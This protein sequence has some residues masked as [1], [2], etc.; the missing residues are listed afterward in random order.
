LAEKTP[1]ADLGVIASG[2]PQSTQSSHA[3]YLT[4]RALLPPKWIYEAEADACGKNDGLDPI[5]R[6]TTIYREPGSRSWCTTL[7]AIGERA[8]GL[9]LLPSLFLQPLPWK[10]LDVRSQLLLSTA[11]ASPRQRRTALLVGIIVLGGFLATAPFAQVKL[12][13]FP[14]TILIQNTLTL[15]NDTL[16]AAVLFGQYAVNRSRGLCIL[17]FGFLFT[18]LM[19]AAH[20]LSF[21]EVFSPTGLLNGGPQGTPWLYMVWHAVL[22]ATVVAFA[23][24]RSDEDIDRATRTTLAP[25]VMTIVVAGCLA[26]ASTWLI[27]ARHDWLP[28]LIEDGRLLSTTKI[29]VAVQLLLPLAALLALATHK[30][31]SVLDIWLMVLMLTWLCT[32]T[33]VLILGYQRYDVGWY[34]GRIFE[35]FMSILVLVVFLSEAVSLY[36]HNHRGAAIERRER[37]RRISEMEAV[38]VHLSRVNE[39][40]RSLST[41]VHEISQPLATISMLAQTSLRLSDDLSVRLRKLLGPLAEQSARVLAIVQHLRDFL[42]RNE[43]ERV[44]HQIPEMIDDAVRLASLGDKSGLAINTRYHAAATSGFFDRVQIEQ[45]VFNLVRNAIEATADNKWRRLSIASDLTPKGMIE[46]SVADNGP[47]LSPIVRKKLFE[48]FVTT[49]ASGLGI[50]LSIC[51]VII[52]AHGGQLQAKDNPGGGTIFHFTLPPAPPDA[53]EASERRH[54]FAIEP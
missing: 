21:P 26:F 48:P 11:T 43:P 4:I 32:I 36:A 3:L 14:G 10:G 6:R 39:T 2:F 22:P 41:L 13:R 51:Q 31:R 40:G 37:E 23:F 27:T 53:P 29:A 30:S 24:Y 12:A 5:R 35:V 34:G 16:T 50:G 28:A 47:G 17:A 7:S 20:A 46:I 9:T 33:L 15:L 18:A 54:E 38:L 1:V 42:K 19:A 44:I 45:V 49:K 25:I 52:Q 8:S